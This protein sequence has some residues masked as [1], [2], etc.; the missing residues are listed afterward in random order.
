LNVGYVAY[1]NTANITQA[2]SDVLEVETMFKVMIHFFLV[3]LASLGRYPFLVIVVA[4]K[5]QKFIYKIVR[6]HQ[7][8]KSA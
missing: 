2:K 7:V 8:F 1:Y 6:N 4:A 3:V 5:L